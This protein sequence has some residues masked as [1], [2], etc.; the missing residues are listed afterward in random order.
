MKI[1]VYV[2]IIWGGFNPADYYTGI[3]G[4]EEKLIEWARYFAKENDVT[5]Y[6]NGVHGEVD[7]VKYVPHNQFKSYEPCDVF[8]SFKA[9]HILDQSINAKKIIHWTADIEGEWPS[10]RL[11][12]VD[13]VSCLSGFH[14]GKMGSQEK[15]EIDYL[16]IEDETIELV[17]KEPG[18]MLY[19]SSYDRGLEDLLNNWETIKKELDLKKLYVT[20]GWDFLDR[21]IR[22]NPGMRDWKA[23]MDEMLTQEGIEHLGRLPRDEM[24]QMYLR[25][26]Y[27]C[28]PVNRAESELF[29]INAIKAQLGM[30]KPV[31]RR[32]GALQETVL[33]F[34]DYDG[35]LGQKV[36][37]DDWGENS[38]EEN[39]KHALGFSFEKAMNKWEQILKS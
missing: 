10:S 34:I 25:S 16:W 32:I 11:D 30:C 9:G 18:T 33:N 38:L 15:A 31:V 7:G 13:R 29:C 23:R 36:G 28:M 19:C 17:D 27:W 3:G 39:R 22:M 20:Y 35:L 14:R 8:I 1:K 12:I 2:N 6:M 37:K 26:E 24:N 5:V 4:S 21:S